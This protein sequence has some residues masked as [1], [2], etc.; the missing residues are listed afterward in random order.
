MQ[1]YILSVIG[2]NTASKPIQSHVLQP[3]HLPHTLSSQVHLSQSMPCQWVS[4]WFPIFGFLCSSLFPFFPSFP[5]VL[6]F[7]LLFLHSSA[8]LSTPSHLFLR[9]DPFSL[10]LFLFSSSLFIPS[11]WSPLHIKYVEQEL[12]PFLQ[13]DY[14]FHSTLCIDKQ[15][16]KR[17]K[18]V[19]GWPCSRFLPPPCST[20]HKDKGQQTNDRPRC[21]THTGRH[22][23]SGTYLSYPTLFF[24]TIHH[25]HNPL[26]SSLHS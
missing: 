20:Q 16:Q 17:V 13:Q 18:A 21:E 9:L 14:C 12:S 26:L 19:R 22:H 11:S 1:S 6:L 24:D 25:T 15:Q 8:S 4:R 23:F 2:V 5:S 10:F 7:F 3:R